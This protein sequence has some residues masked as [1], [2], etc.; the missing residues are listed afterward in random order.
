MSSLLTALHPITFV[1]DIRKK[2]A[3]QNVCN[4]RE[5]KVSYCTYPCISFQASYVHYS[6]HLNMQIDIILFVCA[7][8]YKRI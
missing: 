5:N 7:N 6:S 2:E 4:D 3:Q 1:Y 8:T